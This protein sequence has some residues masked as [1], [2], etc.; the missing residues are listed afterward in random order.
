M[1][2]SSWLCRDKTKASYFSF[3]PVADIYIFLNGSLSDYINVV[4]D[5][6]NILR[7]VIRKQQSIKN[8]IKRKLQNRRTKNNILRK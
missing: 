7:G 1:T 4:N 3:T 8:K 2:A 6:K 5:M